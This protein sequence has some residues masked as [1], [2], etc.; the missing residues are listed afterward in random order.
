[1]SIV[2]SHVLARELLKKEDGFITIT[3]DNDEYLV[4]SIRRKPTYANVDDS[5]TY[6]TLNG[7]YKSKGNIKI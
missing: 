7:E 6:W 1:M 5:S 3:V 2:T 4:S